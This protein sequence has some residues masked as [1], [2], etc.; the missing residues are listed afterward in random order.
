MT[1]SEER[2]KKREVILKKIRLV[3][4]A[5]AEKKACTILDRYLEANHKNK[6]PERSFL[7]SLMYQL[8]V[9]ADVETI[10]SLTEEHF[11]HVSPTTVYYALQLFIKAKIVRSI[12]LIENGRVFYE[13]TVDAPPLGYV[14][15]RNCGAIK[16]F[17]LSNVWSEAEQHISTGYHIDDITTIVNGTCRTCQR[18][19]SKEKAA[20]RK[21]KKNKQK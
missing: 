6:T 1:K 20:I 17:P 16:T 15:C 12:N 11:G 5:E 10:H 21:Q 9:P 4:N 19:I 2:A 7:L 8:T 18:K 14:I 13:K 3:K